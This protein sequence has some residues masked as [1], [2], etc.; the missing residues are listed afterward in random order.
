MQKKGCCFTALVVDDDDVYQLVQR[1]PL[2][3]MHKHN[4]QYNFPFLTIHF[5]ITSS[6]HHVMLDLSITSYYTLHICDVCG[7]VDDD[8][9]DYVISFLLVIMKTRIL[10]KM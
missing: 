2:H 3:K 10:E 4:L 6:H 5:L 7:D 9:H 1:L 8:K